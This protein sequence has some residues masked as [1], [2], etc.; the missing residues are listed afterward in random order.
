[1]TKWICKVCGYIHEGPE[2]P[3]ICPV[4][5]AP[6]S[7]FERLE[8]PAPAKDAPGASA[9]PVAPLD[10]AGQGV[11]AALAAVSYG[12][13]I[14]SSRQGDRVNGQTANTVFQITSEPA[15][16]GVGIN[17]SNYTHEFIKASQVATITVLGQDNLDL[18]RAFGFR[19]GRD[20]DK[21]A[22]VRHERSPVVGCPILA[23]GLAYLE[24]RIDAAR[25]VDVGTHTL[26]IAEVV[27][28]GVLR[29]G[30]PMT[31][32]YYRANRSR[33]TGG[34][35]A[36]GVDA[37]A[38][39]RDVENAITT[40]NLELGATKRYEHQ[41]ATLKNPRLNTIF[42]GIRRTEGDHVENALE[43]I[44]G[45]RQT[46]ATGFRRAELYLDLNHEFEKVATA[47]YRRFAEEAADPALKAT[48]KDMA[49][50]EAGHVNIFRT[51]LEEVRSGKFPV[52]FYCPLCG[53]E[54]DFGTGPTEGREERCAKCGLKVRLALKDGDWDLVRV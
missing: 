50:S 34:S 26:F 36:G 9:A 20:A 48:F 4:C 30:E 14:V 44:L 27:G 23:D 22:G 19:S 3:E 49:Q 8:E 21:F 10:V 31:Y 43:F 47:T 42:E 32:A 13:F 51:L 2:P 39:A 53:W 16:L 28:G 38:V 25:S 1:M 40:F 45:H 35:A 6:A 54:I 17:Q 7:E 41:M 18:V 52:V 33:P 37:A 11:K 12:L 29:E 5:G 46:T 15:R 24:V